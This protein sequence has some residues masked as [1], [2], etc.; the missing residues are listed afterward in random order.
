MQICIDRKKQACCTHWEDI[1]I[2]YSEVK[3]LKLP[4]GICKWTSLKCY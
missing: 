2:N 3:F 1:N 4:E